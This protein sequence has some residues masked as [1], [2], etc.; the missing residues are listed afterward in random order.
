VDHE[1]DRLTT[2]LTRSFDG[3]A[4]HGPGILETLKDVTA[5]MA[6]SHPIADA[7]SIW[8][9][10]LHLGGTYGLVLRRLRG[11]D[12]QLAPSE[13]WPPVPSPTPAG[14]QEAIRSLQERH[15]QLLAAIR[16]FSP[17]R[18]DRPLSAGAPYSA[19]VQFIGVTQHD[20][21]HAGQIMLL[22]KAYAGTKSAPR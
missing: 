20:L 3:E 2:Q 19:Y 17:R 11:E 6:Y 16:S 15:A 13:D 7:H 21:Y 1:L 8:E 5:E 4:W 9:L 12:A 22:R 10:V 18:L 14:W